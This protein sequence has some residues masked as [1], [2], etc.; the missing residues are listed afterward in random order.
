M[1]VPNQCSTDGGRNRAMGLSSWG[2]TVPPYGAATAISTMSTKSNPPPARVGLRCTKRRS[3]RWR[4]VAWQRFGRC[5]DHGV[6]PC[7][8]LVADTRV[9]ER[10]CH[11]H[12]QIHQYI[13][14]RKD[15]DNALNDRIIAVQNGIYGQAA[16]AGNG[17][18]AF[19]HHDPTDQEGHAH[20]N[21]SD[22]W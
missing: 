19:G 2:S 18:D 13:D 20:P 14:T 17:K 7:A 22:D 5:C 9:E 3:R 15:Q 6:W 16:Q 1:S 8:A 21:N 11:I 4:L 12:Q 10:V